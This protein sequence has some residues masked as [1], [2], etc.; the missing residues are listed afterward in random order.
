MTLDG[1]APGSTETGVF[2]VDEE[3]KAETLE[4]RKEGR[5]YPPTTDIY[6]RWRRNVSPHDRR[7]LVAA[8]VGRLDAYKEPSG[9]GVRVDAMGYQGYVPPPEF[10]PLI[11]AQYFSRIPDPGNSFL[12]THP[13]NA[14]RLETVRRT[15]A[16]LRPPG[17]SE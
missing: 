13:P 5:T 14:K 12:G 16:S 2:W 9:V 8:G 1:K 10:D 7:R 4:A 15:L 3:R 11:G 6:E 17:S